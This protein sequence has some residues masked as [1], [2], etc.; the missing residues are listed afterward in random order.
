MPRYVDYRDHSFQSES[1]VRVRVQLLSPKGGAGERPLLIYV[2]RPGD[3]IYAMDMDE[4]LPL[5]GRFTVVIL[6]PYGSRSWT[7]G[8]QSTRTWKRT[9]VWVGRTIAA[10]RLWDIRRTI[11]WVLED[12]RLRV[13]DFGLRQGRHGDPGALCRGYGFPSGHGDSERASGVAL[14]RAGAAQCSAGDGYRRSR[15]ALAPRRWFR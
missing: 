2:K 9:A 7:L 15:G 10:M 5:L 12:Q 6:N 1:G 3:S 11:D 8:R 14:A 13:R 4:L